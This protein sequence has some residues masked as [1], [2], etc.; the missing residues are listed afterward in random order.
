MIEGGAVYVRAG[1]PRPHQGHGGR[2]PK[3]AGHG[4]N[5]ERGTAGVVPAAHQEGRHMALRRDL[6]NLMFF[7]AG[8]GIMAAGLLF[9]WVDRKLLARFQNRLGPRWFQPFADV[10]KLL[11]KEEIQPQGTSA[12][13]FAA[14]P[15]IALTGALTAALA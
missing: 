11:G 3:A 2:G 1:S 13:L 5:N 12:L 10:V 9:Q 14:L 6:F 15:I 7:P 4:T 8:L